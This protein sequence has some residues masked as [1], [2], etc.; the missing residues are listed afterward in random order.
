MS[1]LSYDLVDKHKIDSLCQSIGLSAP[2]S[3]L[4]PFS[5]RTYPS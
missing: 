1:E 5:M 2:Q 4:L 3:T